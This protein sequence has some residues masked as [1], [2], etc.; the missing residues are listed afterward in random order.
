MYAGPWGF[1]TKPPPAPD[2][3]DREA[4][5]RIRDWRLH[6]L[7]EVAGLDVEDAEW[8]A[9]RFDIDVQLVARMLARGCPSRTVMEILL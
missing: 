2:A 6:Q 9:A 4:W 7:I 5:E 1:H 3:P 8:L